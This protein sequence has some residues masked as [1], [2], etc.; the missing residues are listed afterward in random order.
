MLNVTRRRGFVAMAAGCLAVGLLL[1]S[2]PA[3]AVGSSTFES[4][5]GNTPRNGAP[6]A[7]DWDELNATTTLETDTADTPS[8]ANDESFTQ[9]TKSD[10]AVPTIETGSIPPNKSDLTRMRV[11]SETVGGH[12]MLYVAWNRSNTLGSANMNFE[13]NESTTASSNGITPARTEG[14][15]LITFD[16]ANGGNHVDLGLARWALTPCVANGAKAPDCWGDFDDLDAAGFADG[17]VSADGKFGEAAID[18]TA[19]GVFSANECTA[20]GSAYLTSRSSNSFTA[21]LKDFVPPADIN[22]TTC[23]AFKI[24][25]TA[26]HKDANSAPNLQA[27]FDVMQGTTVVRTVQTDPATGEVCVNELPP[28]SYTVDETLG[29]AGYLLDPSIEPVTVVL[30]ETCADTSVSFEN[31]PLSKFT[32]TFESLVTGGT[33]SIISCTG[34]G[35]AMDPDAGPD[36]GDATSTFDDTSEAYGG[37]QPGLY[38]CMINVDP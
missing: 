25:K 2:G 16:F 4:T 15:V 12:V 32:V 37:L 27:T 21:A 30:G 5:D 7:Q 6:P 36:A 8:G 28:G 38:T 23:G 24:I 1:G 17:S 31:I 20:L 29:Q 3:P 35:G 9:G 13:F 26:K 14:D 18:L 34:P 11:A 19:A 22:I 33:A 10:T